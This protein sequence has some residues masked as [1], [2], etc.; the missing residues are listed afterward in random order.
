VPWHDVTFDLAFANGAVLLAG[1][2]LYA[3]PRT[4]PFGDRLRALP[5]SA[6]W[7]AAP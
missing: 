3:G 7:N 5:I 6:L 1:I 4:L 2:V